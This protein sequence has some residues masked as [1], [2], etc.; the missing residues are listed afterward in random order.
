M[1]VRPRF[2]LSLNWK[3]TLF[4]ALLFPL[5][6]YLGFWQLDR[7]NQ[8]QIT[9]S[10][11]AQL[12]SKVAVD[13]TGLTVD[14]DPLVEYRRVRGEGRL[15]TKRYWL[16]ENKVVNGKI[17]AYVVAPFY[18]DSGLSIAVN[19]GWVVLPLKRDEE[20]KIDIKKARTYV[21][22]TLSR[23]SK[24]PLINE[25]H[26]TFKAWPHRLL[27]IDIYQMQQHLGIELLPLV[28]NLDPDNP[29]AKYIN[30]QPVNMPP[31]KHIGYAVQWFSLALALSILWLIANSN[32]VQWLKTRIISSQK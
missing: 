22:G 2:I 21:S 23:P 10:E 24:S 13:L 3:I 27:Q 4:C 26:N 9:L 19:L 25:S 16:V 20:I 15:D 11:L 1:I 28:V 29:N 18:L 30:W 5:L 14:A 17:G 12:E 31:S 7:A 6:M 32:I 8:K